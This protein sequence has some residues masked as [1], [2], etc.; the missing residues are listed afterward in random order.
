MSIWDKIGTLKE[1]LQERLGRKFDNCI[2]CGKPTRSHK[3]P[4][5]VQCHSC[6][7]RLVTDG[8]TITPDI[9]HDF[10]YVPALKHRPNQP[11]VSWVEDCPED[12]DPRTEEN[13]HLDTYDQTDPDGE[14]LVVA[15]RDGYF[16]DIDID[17]EEGHDTHVDFDVEELDPP[18]QALFFSSPSG[19]RHIVL[20]LSE[21]FQG[22]NSIP[23]VDLQSDIRGNRG[24]FTSP[25]HNDDYEI[26]QEGDTSVWFDGTLEG[27]DLE[28]YSQELVF[29]AQLLDFDDSFDTD[30]ELE[31]DEEPP[32]EMPTCLHELLV[33]R[34]TISDDDDINAWKVDSAAGRRLVAFGYDFESSIDLLGEYPPRDGFDERESRY[35]MRLLYQKELHP[36][37]RSTIRRY[38]VE[39]S[40]CNCRFCG[41]SKDDFIARNPVHANDWRVEVTD[42]ELPN[43]I[44]P[45]IARTGKSYTM[46]GEAARL[47]KHDEFEDK[48][49]AYLSSTHSEAEATVD[50]FKEH[51]VVDVAYLIGQRK[52]EKEYNVSCGGDFPVGKS[53]RSPQEAARLNCQNQY[54]AYELG[55]KDAQV[56]V[57]V[58]EKLEDI[59]ERDWIIMTEEAAFSRILSTS[60]TAINVERLAGDDRSIKEKL[61][62]RQD[63]FQN[64]IDE[65]DDKEQPAQAHS[66][67]RTTCQKL[68]QISRRI[69]NWIPANWETVE[70]SWDTLVDDIERLLN[71]I[72]FEEPPDFDAAYSWLDRYQE[73]RTDIMNVMF[74]DGTYTYENDEKKQF[75]IIGDCERLFIPF[76]EDVDTLWTA[77]NSLQ[78]MEHFH[79][80]VHGDEYQVKPFLGGVTPVQDSIRVLKYTG[81]KNQNIQANHVQQVIENA[82]RRLKPGAENVSAILISGSSKHCASHA[83]RISRCITP[84]SNDTLEDVRHYLQ[85]DFVVAIPENSRYSEGVDTPE[86]DCGALYNGSFATPRED[87]MAEEYGRHDLKKAEKI[88]AAQNS[89]LRPSDIL[90]DDMKQYG[91]GITPVIVPDKHVPDEIW[92]LFEEYGITVYEDDSLVQLKKTFITFLKTD[93]LEVHDGKILHVDE[94]PEEI[95]DVKKLILEHGSSSRTAD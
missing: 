24:M 94:V 28:E 43:I 52:A 7:T 31:I 65:I 63:K 88:R 59:G 76:P 3:V 12:I 67:I 95:S 25:F 68:I 8:G 5:G 16:L 50:K 89:I 39:L 87:Y 73:L 13:P 32:D 72:A 58:P 36:D 41:H 18:H 21:A 55:C 86:A 57:T 74:M 47:L 29:G 61:S 27:L 40:S 38:G 46:V 30:F 70:E 34:K 6:D 71:D 56:V 26:L 77:G 81:G 15:H 82:Q 4:S 69:E 60:V 80:I 14:Y 48:Q 44:M 23:G 51:S 66:W 85:H 10:L 54:R 35:Q 9:A 1:R 2:S 19:G 90:D 79:E 11:A 42:G 49:I 22:L 53:A 78:H 84:S 45:S 83:T 62:R 20:R 37:N 33:A 17:V 92:E 75:F 93:K 91:T 64:V